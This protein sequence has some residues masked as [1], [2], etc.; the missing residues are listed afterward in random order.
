MRQ[1][2][3]AASSS[4]R[5]WH[6]ASSSGSPRLA[7]APDRA[8]RVDDVR[9]GRRPAVVAFASPVTQPP[10]RR[11]SA[12]IA[13]AAGA[14]DGAVDAAAAEQ[15]LVGGVDDRVDDL[16]GDVAADDLDA[17][18]PFAVSIDFADAP[19]PILPRRTRFQPEDGRQGGDAAGRH[20]LHRPRGRRRAAREERRH[21]PARRRRAHRPRVDGA[22]ARR[23]RQRRRH[24]VVLPRHPLRRRGRPGLARLHHGAEGAGARSG[25]V[26][27]PPADAARGRARHARSASGSRSRSRARAAPRTCRR[28]PTPPTAS[29]RSSSGPATTPPT[30]ASRSSAWAASTS[31]TPATSGTTSSRAS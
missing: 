14:V 8:D 29:R 7:A 28:S 21:A 10:S 23:A 16:L 1:P 15:R 27:A 2:S 3:P 24:D 22:D 30:S 25:R 9:A 20:G 19:P 6:E 18:R 17:I 13:R 12:R 26:R 11:H 5:R 31:S 4:E